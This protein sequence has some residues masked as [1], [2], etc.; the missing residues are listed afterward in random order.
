MTATLIDGKAIAARMRDETRA[1]A[2][3]LNVMVG[4]TLDVFEALKP[5]LQA[6]AE[7]VIHVGGPGAGSLS[8]WASERRRV[9]RC[10]RL[11]GTTLTRVHGTRADRWRR[12]FRLSCPHGAESFQGSKKRAPP[13]RRC[14]RT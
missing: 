9:V 1:E 2:G 10:P 12:T 14:S 5:I 4:A 13:P 7:N 11:P 6:F 3:R 8:P